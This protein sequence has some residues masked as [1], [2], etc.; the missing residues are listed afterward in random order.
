MR[1]NDWTQLSSHISELLTINLN[2]ER[3][4]STV[5]SCHMM[6]VCV[7]RARIDYGKC[8]ALSSQGVLVIKVTK[9]D[10][11]TGTCIRNCVCVCVCV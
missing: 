8:G 7:F 4:L 11:N 1:E 9:T 5:R 6:R 10:F 2:L 3:C